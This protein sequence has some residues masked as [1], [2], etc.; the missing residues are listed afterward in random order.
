MKSIEVRR[1]NQLYEI[2]IAC[3]IFRQKREVISGIAARGRPIFMRSGRNVRLASN[4]GLDSSA[5][6]F[7]IKFNRAK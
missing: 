2:A 4:D 7:L 1:R 5:D 3:L 6:S